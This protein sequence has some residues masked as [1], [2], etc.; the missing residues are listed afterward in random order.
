MVAYKYK[1][2]HKHTTHNTNR[3]KTQHRYLK[4]TAHTSRGGDCVPAVSVGACGGRRSIEDIGG[5]YYFNKNY[6][7]GVILYCLE[8]YHGIHVIIILIIRKIMDCVAAAVKWMR[9]EFLG[10]YYK[11]SM[12]Q[13]IYLATEQCGNSC[14]PFM[15]YTFPDQLCKFS[16]ALLIQKDQTTGMLTFGRGLIFALFH[17]LGHVCG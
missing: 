3:W 11:N 2:Q 17:D 15:D 5:R 7:Y 4:N 10:S 1:T 12:D 8:K 16:Y 13:A 9:I 6:T 14:S